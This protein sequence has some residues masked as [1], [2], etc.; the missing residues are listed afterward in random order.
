MLRLCCQGRTTQTQRMAAPT[1]SVRTD[2]W[3]AVKDWQSSMSCTSATNSTL[4]HE[5]GETAR[6]AVV[7]RLVIGFQLTFQTN[8][9]RS[10]FTFL[11]STGKQK[12]RCTLPTHCVWPERTE[13][14]VHHTTSLSLYLY[15]CCAMFMLCCADPFYRAVMISG[16]AM[17][18]PLLL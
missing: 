5:G 10:N 6:I 18:F 13:R 2:W 1:Q 17:T 14:E 3:W 8:R 11:Q 16:C 9:S 12:A 4:P 7:R 15:V